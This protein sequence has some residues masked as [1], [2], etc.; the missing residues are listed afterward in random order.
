MALPAVQLLCLEQRDRSLELHTSDFLQLA[1]Q[2]NFPDRSLCVFYHTGLSERSKAC[3]PAGGPTEDFA[4][5]VEWVL[6]NN[7]SLFTICPA[8]DDTSTA[9][10]PETSHPPPTT[11]TM[12][13]Q[14]PTADRGVQP[15]GTNK[16][17]P[18]ERTEGVVAPGCEPQG[19]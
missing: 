13:R 15:A 11:C 4:T 2:T 10:H 9:P 3:I 6:V 5:Y 19:V 17:E 7:N 16:T 1:C 12:E 14:E 8:E 18:E